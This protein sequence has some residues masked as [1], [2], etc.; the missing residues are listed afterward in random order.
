MS[1]Q[2]AH[3]RA[4]RGCSPAFRTLPQL[5]EGSGLLPVTRMNTRDAMLGKADTLCEVQEKAKRLHC[6]SHKTGGHLGVGGGTVPRKA[7]EGAFWGDGNALKL[8]EGGGDTNVQPLTLHT[9]L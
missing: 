2:P 5:E 1:F 4:W 8:T 9:Q 7:L 6:D 3:S